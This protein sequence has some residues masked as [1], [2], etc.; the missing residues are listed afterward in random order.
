LPYVD[1]D[2]LVRINEARPLRN[3]P[4]IGVAIAEVWDYR[5]NL[6]TIADVV[7]YH[8]MNFV[9]LDKGD[10][11]RVNTGVVSSSYFDVFGIKP[12]VGRTFGE[13]ADAL[14]AEP[15][16]VRSNAYWLKHFGGDDHIVGRRVVMND[17]EH[18]VVGIL[19]PIPGYPQENDVYMPT[20]ACP[21]R[22]QA[23]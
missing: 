20:S 1:G 8:R 7:E 11:D 13:S 5:K 22:A 15:V 2:R 4:N 9:L 19:P 21:F 12:L 6:T 16:L 14:G 3:Q 23:Q 18:T 17:K 10:A